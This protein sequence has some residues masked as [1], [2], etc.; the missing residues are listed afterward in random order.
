ML[1]RGVTNVKKQISS[2]EFTKQFIKNFILNGL[3]I[4]IV[5][6]VIYE[7]IA[8]FITNNIIK[9]I[10]YFI[11]IF[12]VINKTHIE[13]L[14]DTFYDNSISGDDIKKSKK[15]I[16]IFF[17][18]IVLFNIIWDFISLIGLNAVFSSFASLYLKPLIVNSIINI[19]LYSIIIIF[20]RDEINKVCIESYKS[21]NKKNVLIPIFAIVVIIGTIFIN[22]NKSL[23]NND[24]NISNNITTVGTI[25]TVKVT[26]LNE[27]N[28]E[29]S[30][31]TITEYKDVKKD[32]LKTN[33]GKVEIN[34]SSF[35]TKI[36]R[37]YVDN[38]YTVTDGVIL[39]YG[40]IIEKFDMDG[41]SNWKCEELSKYNLS[42]LVEV[43]DG[44]FLIGFFNGNKFLIK[45]D[46]NGNIIVKNNIDN[47]QGIITFI[48]SEENNKN[49]CLE[50]MGKDDEENN[51]IVKYDSEGNQKNIITTNLANIEI[52]KI[53]EKNGY[54]YAIGEDITEKHFNTNITCLFKIDNNGNVVFKYDIEENRDFIRHIGQ[55]TGIKDIS[56]NNKY[57]FILVDGSEVCAL[58]LNGNLK[59]KFGYDTNSKLNKG[60]HSNLDHIKATRDGVYIYGTT[61]GKNI[62]KVSNDFKFQYRITVSDTELYPKSTI[63][64]SIESSKLLETMYMDSDL[65]DSSSIIIYQY[66]FK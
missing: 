18:I 31:N 64:N 66:K 7:I 41:Q 62:D 2:K 37:T 1:K 11:L 6:G 65:Y 16:T 32:Y 39:F 24:T 55:I 42:D 25:E 14:K 43:S 63:S 21:N 52:K 10:L 54:Y 45:F 9:E 46:K 12:I 27:I 29:L 51:I 40:G 60:R 20:C 28:C 49:N 58:D 50:I 33:N 47:V 61:A 3:I 44:Y 13:A 26:S 15:N 48:D 17:L 34:I 38:E 8:N 23:E 56:V 19:V 5:L 53:L 4:G 59:A 57:I 22:Q 30:N 36:P 35:D